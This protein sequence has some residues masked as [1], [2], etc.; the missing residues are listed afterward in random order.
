M[1]MFTILQQLQDENHN[2]A[3]SIERLV[4]SIGHIDRRLLTVEN[5]TGKSEMRSIN[6]DI[7]LLKNWKQEQEKKQGKTL[8]WWHGVVMALIVGLIEFFVI[9]FAFFVTQGGNTALPVP[10]KPDSGQVIPKVDQLPDGFVYHL[11]ENSTALSAYPPS[12]PLALYFSGLDLFLTTK[13][14][15]RS[16]QNESKL[17]HEAVSVP[18]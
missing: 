2:T 6:D 1:Q 8:Q 3:L 5:Y 17:I 12:R 9:Y 15:K 7:L 10:S 4:E 14:Q 13:W 16:G 18:R 11:H